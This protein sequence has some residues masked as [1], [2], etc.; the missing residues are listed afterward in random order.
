MYKSFKIIDDFVKEIYGFNL[1]WEPINLA[2]SK[3]KP[4]SNE[5]VK[6][7]YPLLEISVQWSELKKEGK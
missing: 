6:Y 3:R 4:Y 5:F 2:E 7:V 1:I